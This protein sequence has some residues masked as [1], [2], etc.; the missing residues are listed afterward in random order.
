MMM[1]SFM[2]HRICFF[3]SRLIKNRSEYAQFSCAAPICF[4][5]SFIF[6]KLI[7]L[8]FEKKGEKEYRQKCKVS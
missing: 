2:T 5:F 8:V 4:F 3:V 1:M 6:A 7:I